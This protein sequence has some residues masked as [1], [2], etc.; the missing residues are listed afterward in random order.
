MCRSKT[1]QGG[2]TNLDSQRGRHFDKGNVKGK[3]RGNHVRYVEEQTFPPSRDTFRS[4]DSDSDDAYTH[5]YA[6]A[7]QRNASTFPVEISGLPVGVMIDSGASCN[8][9]NSA[10]ADQLRDIGSRFQKCQRFIHPYRSPPIECKECLTAEISVSGVQP[11]SADFLVV[12][13]SAPSLLS[14]ITA[15]KLGILKVGVNHV[16]QSSLSPSLDDFL[17]KYPGLCEGIGC[18]KNAEVTLHIDK[19]VPPV[20][21]KYNH[22]PFHMRDKVAQEIEKLEKEGIIEKVSGPTEWVSR[23]VTPPKPKSP[24]EI[25]LCVD[26][27]AAN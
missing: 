24:G 21:L 17:A 27:R 7:V 10:M 9:V 15:E 12:P 23:I 2:Q 20:A 13:G 3:S 6:F 18:L 19:S 11:V 22:T 8:I 25:R 4:P 16:S 14:R 1:P 26:M 5:E